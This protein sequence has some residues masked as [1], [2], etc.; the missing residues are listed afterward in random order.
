[1]LHSVSYKSLSLSLVMGFTFFGL[2]SC[3]NQPKQQPQGITQEQLTSLLDSVKKAAKEEAK[4]EL[5][6]EVKAEMQSKNEEQSST[7]TTSSSSSSSSSSPTSPAE[8]AYKEGYDDGMLHHAENLSTYTNRNEQ[9]LKK[10][11]M[12]KCRYGMYGIGKEN[13]NN[14]ALYNEYRRGFLK[15]YEDGNNAL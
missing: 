3:N 12:D 10:Q 2:C 7:S 15:G 9:W 5:E 1:M 11:Y 8:A 13:Y 14:R 6:E 4:E